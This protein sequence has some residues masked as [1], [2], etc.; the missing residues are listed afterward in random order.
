MIVIEAWPLQGGKMWG[1]DHLTIYLKARLYWEPGLD[2]AGFLDEYYTLF[3]GPAAA[4]MREFFEFAEQVWMR[5]APR[6]HL[7]SS[8]LWT[9]Y[10]ITHD[11]IPIL[12][13]SF[14]GYLSGEPDD[15]MLETFE[16]CE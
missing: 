10:T 2:L 15:A 7:L 14:I 13:E 12:Y 4:E 5:P 3:Y 8:T 6:I 11:T 1:I 16:G 9:L